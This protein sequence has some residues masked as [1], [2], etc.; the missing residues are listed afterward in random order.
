MLFLPWSSHWDTLSAQ[1]GKNGFTTITQLLWVCY[2]CH[3]AIM[4]RKAFVRLITTSGSDNTDVYCLLL[5]ASVKTSLYR[6][7]EQTVKWRLE[8]GA[9]YMRWG[10]QPRRDAFWEESR[11]SCPSHQLNEHT[12]CNRL[13]P[14]TN[15]NLSCNNLSHVFWK[16]FCLSCHVKRG[17]ENMF[18]LMST[19]CSSCSHHQMTEGS[20]ASCDPH[21]R[22][23]SLG[24]VPKMTTVSPAVVCGRLQ[25][26]AFPSSLIA[27]LQVP[28]WFHP[29]SPL[30]C[31]PT[32]LVTWLS[33]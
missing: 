24:A 32:H 25:L 12:Y 9:V 5:A 21:T 28:C 31:F 27:A 23:R 1:G 30:N 15:N 16:C 22:S 18:S 33:W 13:Q 2:S 7:T 26:P 29:R 3:G 4:Q 17:K 11:V 8:M 20:Q 14:R 19:F 10:L 6:Q